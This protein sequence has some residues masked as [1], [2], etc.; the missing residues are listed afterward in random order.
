MTTADLEEPRFTVAQIEAATGVS[1]HTIRQ[2]YKR[3]VL[4]LGQTDA[5]AAG[6]GLARTFSGATALV[7]AIMGALIK[8]GTHSKLAADAGLRFAHSGNEQRLP[9][10]LFP[11]GETLIGVGLSRPQIWNIDDKSKLSVFL[12]KRNGFAPIVLLPVDQLVDS[13]RVNLG[14]GRDPLQAPSKGKR[15]AAAGNST[16]RPLRERMEA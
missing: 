3:G 1:A 2:W 10:H 9:G 4:V 16:K 7:I 14:L 15:G 6:I 13:V 5:E 12:P 11:E 8:V